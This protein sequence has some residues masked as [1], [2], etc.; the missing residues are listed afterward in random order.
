MTVSIDIQNLT[1]LYPGTTTPALDALRLQVKPGEVYGFLGANGAGK[2]TAIR[3]L[4]N[5]IQPTKGG[6][7][8]MG[9]DVVSGSVRVKKH[10][11]YL[12]GDVALWPRVTGNEMFAYLMKLQSQVKMDYLNDL[13]RRFE[14]EPEKRIDQLSKGNRQ[15]IGVIQALMHEPDVLILDEPT[16]GLDPLMQEVF[17][18]CVREAA[19]RGAAVFVSSHNLAEVQR[20]C[21]RV[22]IIKHGKLIR[23][24]S[25]KDDNNLAVTT[26]R[27]VLAHP[28]DAEKLK[29]NRAIK[30]ISTEGHIAIVQP[31]KT[32]A[33]ALRVLAT[34]NITGMTTQ[35]IDL[36]DEFLGYYGDGA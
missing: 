9:L 15:K 33:E 32:I 30:L 19:T 7:K 5:F 6:A 1:K 28:K 10:V 13:I 2:S 17:Y 18:E 24:Q 16:S 26:F 27:V 31:K 23:E 36:E 25:I 35:Q 11:G 34:C 12:A 4:M 3:L 20:M 8:I 29:S 14:A 21:D 22:G